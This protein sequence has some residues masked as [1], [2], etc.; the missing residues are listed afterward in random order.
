MGLIWKL[1]GV[2][3]TRVCPTGKQTGNWFFYLHSFQ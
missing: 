3:L 1:E 2:P